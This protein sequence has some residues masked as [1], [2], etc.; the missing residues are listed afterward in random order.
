MKVLSILCFVALINFNCKEGITQSGDNNPRDQASTVKPLQISGVYPHLAVF[1]EG[2]GLPCVGNGGEGGIGAITPWAGKLWMVTYSAH[3]P[4]GSSDKLYSID[5]KLQ[6]HIHPESVGGTPANRLIH[7][8]SKQ[9]ITGPYF[10]DERGAVRVIPPSVMP[11]RWTATATHLKDPANMV[12]F[13]DMEGA[14]FEVNV[15]SL[16]VNKLFQK[17]IPGWHGKGGYTAQNKLILANNGEHQKFDIDQKLLQVG[18]EPKNKEEMGVLATW[19]GSNWEIIERKQFTDVTGPGGIYGSPDM[20]SPAWSIGWDKR[21]V[22]LKLLDGGKWFTYRLPK[23]THTYDHWGGWYTEWPRIRE[24]GDDKMLMD[25]HG[26]FYDFPKKFARANS[27]GI[28]PLGSHLRYI[29]DFCNWNGKLVLST[30]ETTILQNSYPGRAQSNLWFGNHDDLKEWGGTSGWGGPWMADQVVAGLPSDA[31]LINGQSKKVLHLSHTSASPVKFTLEVDRAG[32]NKWEVYKKVSVPANGYQY[33]VF[34][35]DFTANWIR[36]KTDKN[37]TA[38]AFFHYQ[39]KAHDKPDVMFNNLADID[40]PGEAKASLIRPAAHNKNL[41][42]VNIASNGPIYQEVNEKLEFSVPAAD[43]SARVGKILAL[44]KEFET[45]A[46]SVIIKDNTGTFRLPKTS[47]V[48]DKP[49]AAGWPRAKREVES[50]RYMFNAHGTLYEVG[51]ESGF[52]A[53]RPVTT[54][55]RKIVDFCT[56]RGLLVI[57]GTKNNASADGHYFTNADKTTGLWFGAIDDLWK[58][59]KPVGEGGLWKDASVT[60]GERSLPFLMTG[61]DQKK[62]SLTADKDVEFTLEVD[63]DHNGFHEFKR[64]KVNAGQTVEFNFPEGFNAHWIRTKSNKDCKATVWM[65]YS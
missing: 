26:M 36:I 32:N 22:I 3:C 20:N 15:H 27:S 33:L 14:L 21:S 63:V 29:P 38:T 62:L 7:T 25:M 9:L 52:A 24:I 64:I 23:A 46:A 44:K 55:K 13:C 45:D 11:G 35:A 2:N 59:G 56:W 53:I 28:T 18:T 1:N 40:E 5:D 4:G 19:D 54:H 39:G 37:C 47:S 61:Y 57:S 43:S 6:L 42:V 12:Y 30:D 16:A 34:P 50:E 65:K 8:S 60:A 17:P 51:R 31:Y 48:Y 49:F 41:Q 58:L 10:I